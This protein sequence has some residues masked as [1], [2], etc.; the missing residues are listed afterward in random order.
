MLGM[1]TGYGSSLWILSEMYRREAKICVFWI[2]RIYIC[3]VYMYFR[4]VVDSPQSKMMY[5]IM[6]INFADF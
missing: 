5:I 6:R 1:C 4:R 2:Y 3:W